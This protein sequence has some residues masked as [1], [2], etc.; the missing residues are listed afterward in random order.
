MII[1]YFETAIL[2]H[3]R[4]LKTCLL[5]SHDTEDEIKSQRRNRYLF[6]FSRVILGNLCNLFHLNKLLIK[7]KGIHSFTRFSQLIRIE[8]LMGFSFFEKISLLESWRL[9]NLGTIFHRFCFYLS[10][11]PNLP[12]LKLGKPTWMTLEQTFENEGELG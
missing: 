11:L 3:A 5:S 2:I 7:K 10:L 12:S 1:S 9:E 8:K 4:R 6:F